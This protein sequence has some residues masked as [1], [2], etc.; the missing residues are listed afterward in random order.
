MKSVPVI[1][2]YGPT[3][4]GEGRYV[5]Q[6]CFFVRFG[7]CDY[8]CSWCDSMFAVDPQEVKKNAVPKAI[9]DIAADLVKLG[10]SRGDTAVFSGGNPAIHDLSEL[11]EELVETFY[12]NIHVETQGTVPAPWLARCHSV[13]IS[14]KP[15]SSGNVTGRTTVENFLD[16]SELLSLS[17]LLFSVLQFKYVIFDEDDLGY[18]KEMVEYFTP[19]ATIFQVG[20]LPE[21]EYS[22]EKHLGK[23]RWLSEI[24]M[25]DSSLRRVSVLPQM[26][27]LTWGHERR[28]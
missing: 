20:T 23:L 10:C 2:V 17:S 9:V 19:I 3:L 25:N 15:P 12:L 21:E 27:V 11:V 28:R 24:V 5:G 26:H 22:L 14:P 18:A 13:C 16:K 4:Q 7:G 8:R 1:E 6:R